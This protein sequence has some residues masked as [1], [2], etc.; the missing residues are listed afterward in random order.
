MEYPEE[1][2]MKDMITAQEVAGLNPAEVTNKQWDCRNA[3]PFFGSSLAHY[4]HTTIE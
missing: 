3:V 2:M 1:V 4:L